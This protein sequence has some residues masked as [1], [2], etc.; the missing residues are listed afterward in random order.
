MRRTAVWTGVAVLGAGALSGCGGAVAADTVAWQP[1]ADLAAY[2]TDLGVDEGVV[3]RLQ[4][5]SVDVPLDYDDPEGRTIEL[6]LSRVVGTDPAAPTLF[7]N[8]GGP[9]V[10]GRSMAA[11]V[12]SSLGLGGTVVGIDLRGIG[13]SSR[14]DCA[15]PDEPDTR[16]DESLAGYADN[17]AAANRDCVEADPEFVGSLTTANAARDVDAVRGALGLDTIDFLGVS[18]GTVLGAELQSSFPEH[19]HRVVLDSMDYTGTSAGDALCSRRPTRTFHRRWCPTRPPSGPGTMV[20]SPPTNPMCRPVTPRLPTTTTP[21]STRQ[22]PS[23]SSVRSIRRPE[24]PT[25]AIAST[26]WAT[27]LS[28]S[29]NTGRSM[30]R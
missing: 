15:E 30:R 20:G 2:V 18:W 14:I 17:I 16:D 21:R 24:P 7:V 5:A 23:S 29:P 12:A 27:A 22:P 6:A 3:D 8:P 4:C 1:C 10:E 26:P 13:Y 9:G 25:S 19:L 11:T 28:S